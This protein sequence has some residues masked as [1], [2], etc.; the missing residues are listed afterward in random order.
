MRLSA[1]GERPWRR[2]A[3]A[4]PSAWYSRR[5]PRKP[6]SQRVRADIIFRERQPGEEAFDPVQFQMPNAVARLFEVEARRQ[7]TDF[8]SLIRDFVCAALTE[9]AEA[10]KRINAE[11]AGD[12]G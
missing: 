6:F 12:Q 8:N 10:S 9:R 1:H 3:A 5:M 11:G 4:S 7:G 2:G